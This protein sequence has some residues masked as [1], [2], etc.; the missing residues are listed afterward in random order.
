M[1]PPDVLYRHSDGLYDDTARA[2]KASDVEP[3]TPE[4]K[5]RPLRHSATCRYQRA[6]ELVEVCPCT[7]RQR[8]YRAAHPH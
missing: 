5:E 3:L 1:T 4:G 2:W 6:P 7:R 8:D